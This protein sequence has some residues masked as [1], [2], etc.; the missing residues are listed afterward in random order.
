VL[1]ILQAGLS[2]QEL[3]R[4]L[5][6]CNT[7]DELRSLL[8]RNDFGFR[9]MSHR[10]GLLAA[11]HLLK[12]LDMAEYFQVDYFL[13]NPIRFRRTV[14][15]LLHHPVHMAPHSRQKCREERFYQVRYPDLRLSRPEL[16]ELT[17]KVTL[18]DYLSFDVLAERSIISFSALPELKTILSCSGH[19][20]VR[21]MYA[22]AHLDFQIGERLN[23]QR[24]VQALGDLTRAG[25][26]RIVARGL[27]YYQQAIQAYVFHVPPLEWTRQQDQA[28]VA[29]LHKGTLQYLA[30]TFGYQPE[31]AE[32]FGADPDVQTIESV[33]ERMH[34]YISQFGGREDPRV[35]GIFEH[36]F[37]YERTYPAYCRS[38]AAV[39]IIR[40]FWRDLERLGARMRDEQGEYV[41][42][43]I[44]SAATHPLPT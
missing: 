12:G 9:I 5:D 1:K 29:E 16:S 20:Y 7:L 38:K 13:L 34:E 36:L 17:S 21:R 37:V 32:V 28:P 10:G 18:E 23:R 14:A 44:P 30:E 6:A 2:E 8:A 27:R 42:R 41:G 3:A 24:I 19:S 35:R 22:F 43:R 33:R 26:S 4:M 40:G 39:E 31:A 11:E 25:T 15:R